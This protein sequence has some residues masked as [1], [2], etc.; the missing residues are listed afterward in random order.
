MG[1]PVK[2]ITGIFKK[3]K[4]HLINLNKKTNYTKKCHKNNG[5]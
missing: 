3:P 4:L 5:L 1:N 2:M